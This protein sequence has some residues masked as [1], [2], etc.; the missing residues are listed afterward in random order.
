MALQEKVVQSILGTNK[1]QQILHWLKCVRVYVGYIY[2][3]VYSIHILTHNKVTKILHVHFYGIKT[4]QQHRSIQQHY[5]Q[6]QFDANERYCRKDVENK[7][8][9]YLL[10]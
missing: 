1:M 8:N 9:V 2:V 10:L 6:T 3:S 5:I 7:N 4:N